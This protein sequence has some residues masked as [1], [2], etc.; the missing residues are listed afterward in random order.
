MPP[1]TLL[2]RPLRSGQITLPA[3]FRCA[4]RLEEAMFLQVTLQGDEL[5]T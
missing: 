4:L 5:R 1:N 3:A 2:A